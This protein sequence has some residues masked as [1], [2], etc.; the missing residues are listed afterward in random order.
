M[1]SNGRRMDWLRIWNKC[2]RKLS[3]SNFRNMPTT[4]VE[5]L[6]KSTINL[7]VEI[8]IGYASNA[9]QSRYWLSQ[10]PWYIHCESSEREM[11]RNKTATTSHSFLSGF[12]V[13]FKEKRYS[14]EVAIDHSGLICMEQLLEWKLMFFG[15]LNHVE[16]AIDTKFSPN[17]FI[18]HQQQCKIPRWRTRVLI[19]TFLFNITL[20]NV[21]HICQ[22]F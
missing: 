22:H 5:V 16:T 3:W 18:L 6:W 13:V 14:E 20:E 8:S 10:L 19:N 7:P 17:N 15:V 12:L 11:W 4:S 1:K 9:H 21:I 2:G